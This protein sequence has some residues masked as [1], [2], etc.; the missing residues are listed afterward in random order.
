MCMYVCVWGGGGHCVYVWF[1]LRFFDFCSWTL[2]SSPTPIMFFVKL[3][4]LFKNLRF[5]ND[6][7]YYYLCGGTGYLPLELKIKLRSVRFC[8]STKIPS[9]GHAQYS[10]SFAGN[11]GCLTFKSSATRSYQCVLYFRV[12]KQWY[13]AGSIWDFELAHGCGCALECLYGHR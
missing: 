8:V 6:G 1:L 3:C 13:M 11:S 4:G 5:R 12:S 10:L 9:E 7:Y 2:P